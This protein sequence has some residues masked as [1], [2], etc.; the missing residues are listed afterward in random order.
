MFGV[1]A[2]EVHQVRAAL[3]RPVDVF[4]RILG[5]E[6]AADLPA[7]DHLGR[8]ARAEREDG[9][10]L[11]HDVD[12]VEPRAAGLRPAD[13]FKAAGHVLLAVEIIGGKTILTQRGVGIVQHFGNLLRAGDA[14]AL[15]RDAAA[16][17][18]RE[19][20]HRDVVRAHGDDFV[21]APCKALGRILGQAR[22][23]VHVDVREVRGAHLLHGTADVVRRMAAADGRKHVIL[24]RLGIDGNA[25]GVVRAQH[26]QLLFIDRVGAA[27]LD[28]QFGEIC[29]VEV[30]LELCEQ[31]VHLAGRQRGRRAAAHVEGLDVQPHLAHEL[32]RGGDLVKER[33][34]VRLHEREGLFHAL[35]HK[36]AIRA[37]RG[38]EGD[39]DVKRN[40][41]RFQLRRRADAGVR[42]L[43]GEAGAGG[44]HAVKLLKLPLGLRLSA[45][46][47][48]RER[49]LCRAHAR[50]TAPCGGD[51]EK[52]LRRAEKA[53]ADGVAAL[54]FLFIV[55][56]G[57]GIIVAVGGG[58]AVDAELRRHLHAII[59]FRERHARP[60]RVGRFID[61]AVDGLF[62]GEER[63]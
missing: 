52:V 7:A 4:T 40:V 56:A 33:L 54:A 26:A 15:K 48:E 23:E 41:V 10:Q 17:F 1:K 34:E 13:I 35:R 21:K 59:L 19:R 3:F 42:R 44:L 58:A 39:A 24:H 8:A 2:G 5:V 18:E 57:E 29:K 53:D 11:F 27:C 50:E 32:P 22:D 46:A 16:L 38:A 49:D 45:L 62:A 37:A 61:R 28:R 6:R 9:V 30:L 55:R 51:A 43:D 31:T 20:V 25:R 60:V 14:A 63:Q 12:V 47:D 36:A